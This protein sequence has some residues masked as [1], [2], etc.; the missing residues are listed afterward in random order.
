MTFYCGVDG[1]RNRGMGSVEHGLD[2][3]VE[4]LVVQVVDLYG[5]EVLLGVE[6]PL[7]DQEGL[8]QHQLL[9]YQGH[10]F[11]LASS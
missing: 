3:V 4:G 7:R 10:T 2:L 6:V 9:S 1:Y 11:I 5:L 8:P